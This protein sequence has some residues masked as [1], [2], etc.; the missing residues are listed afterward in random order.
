[1]CDIEY[2]NN[3]EAMTCVGS[4]LHKEKKIVI[5]QETKFRSLIGALG[6]CEVRLP[7]QILMK[8]ECIFC[9]IA[10]NL[11]SLG[12]LKFVILNDVKTQE[13]TK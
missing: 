5:E 8:L 3:E 6:S 4:Q 7:D 12:R 11:W 2:I 10:K 1:V 9:S 13:D